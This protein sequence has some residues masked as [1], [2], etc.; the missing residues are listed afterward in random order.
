MCRALAHAHLWRDRRGRPRA[1]V[2]G[3]LSP[4]NLM[5]RRDGGVTSIDF[6]VAHTSV[7]GG[8]QV[9]IAPRRRRR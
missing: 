6:G 8:A 7:R 2:H 9:L 1:I 4:S 3:D 5:V